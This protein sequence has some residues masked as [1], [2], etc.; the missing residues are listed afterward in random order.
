[1][2]EERWIKRYNFTQDREKGE[3]FFEHE[4]IFSTTKNY[5]QHKKQELESFVSISPIYNFFCSPF[6]W[7][8]EQHYLLAIFKN[9][10]FNSLNA[11]LVKITNRSNLKVYHLISTITVRDAS[12]LLTSPSLNLLCFLLSFKIIRPSLTSDQ[13]TQN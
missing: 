7:C 8:S 12:F 3:A 13:L 4:R 10:K 9:G 6:V 5:T 1:M 11:K 2:E